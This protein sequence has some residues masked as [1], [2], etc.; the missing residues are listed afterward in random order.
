MILVLM[1]IGTE[2]HW[3]G[4]LKRSS[5]L[6]CCEQFHVKWTWNIRGS[7]GRSGNY[8]FSDSIDFFRLSL[9]QM[10]SHGVIEPQWFFFPFPS[11]HYPPQ[12]SLPSPHWKFIF[13]IVHS[14]SG[15]KLHVPLQT[16]NFVICW[17]GNKSRM[18]TPLRQEFYFGCSLFYPWCL[19]RVYR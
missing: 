17:T 14:P 3:A 18:W 4:R 9:F 16:N 8:S 11:T 15:E 7:E 6:G 13:L 10:K 2:W 1:D 12:P 5:E 19:K